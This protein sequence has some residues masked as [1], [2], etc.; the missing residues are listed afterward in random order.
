MHVNTEAD[1]VPVEVVDRV[2]VLK[3]CVSDEEQIL[4]LSWQSALVDNEVAL[5]VARFVQ[6]LLWVYLE[7]VVAH[8]ETDW[9]KFWG[10]VFATVLDM[11]ESLVRSAVEI[12]EGLLPLKSNLLKNVW[13]NRELGTTSVDNSWIG[14]VFAWLLHRFLSIVHALTLESPG[15]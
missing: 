5:F 9:L 7:H 1:S 11:A 4:V 13:W 15:S 8:L 14:S 2:E 3:E 10:N 12:W 6:I